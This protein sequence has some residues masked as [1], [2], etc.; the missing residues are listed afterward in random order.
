MCIFIYIY[1]NAKFR[2]DCQVRTNNDVGLYN[3]ESLLICHA[4]SHGDEFSFYD[5][6]PPLFLSLH[7]KLFFPFL[8]SFSL[9]FFFFFFLVFAFFF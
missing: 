1:T 3:F 6:F 4:V 5:F 2:Q 8:L 7:F 9:V